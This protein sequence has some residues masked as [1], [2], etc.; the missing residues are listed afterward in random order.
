MAAARAPLVIP[1]LWNQ[2]G[3]KHTQQ[4]K[5]ETRAIPPTTAAVRRFRAGP[6][7][8]LRLSHGRRF[9]FAGQLGSDRILVGV[10]SSISTGNKSPETTCSVGEIS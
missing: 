6:V 9:G 5:L 2:S 8:S 7:V 3:Q 1:R 10:V 4:S